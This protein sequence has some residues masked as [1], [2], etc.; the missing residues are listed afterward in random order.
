MIKIEA[1]DV[2]ITCE[3]PEQAAP[4]LRILRE[5]APS[6]AHPPAAKQKRHEAPAREAAEPSRP[7]GR[8]PGPITEAVRAAA[9]ALEPGEEVDADAVAKRL[10]CD[11]RLVKQAIRRLLARGAGQ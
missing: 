5:P 4:L 10:R 9:A 3:T 6:A 2:V 7:K 8:P 11:V 1:G